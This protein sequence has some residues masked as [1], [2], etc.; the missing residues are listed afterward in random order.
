[1]PVG[2]ILGAK[3]FTV[4]ATLAD[5]FGRSAVLVRSVPVSRLDGSGVCFA[6]WD[7][8][9]P[10]TSAKSPRGDFL[11]HFSF[12]RQVG[13]GVTGRFTKHGEYPASGRFS[14]TLDSASLQLVLDDGT[15]MAG[16]VGLSGPYLFNGHMQLT[17]LGGSL[18]PEPAWTSAVTIRIDSAP[19][20]PILPFLPLLPVLPLLPLDVQSPVRSKL[21]GRPPSRLTAQRR[22]RLP[23]A[24]RAEARRA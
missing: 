24:C 16:F 3:D 18:W 20:P 12:E 11:G 1:M 6:G 10:S 7:R 14:G 15:K 2:A 4:R 21:D 22:D 13:P 9:T 17:P 8:I 23:G 19:L 5:E